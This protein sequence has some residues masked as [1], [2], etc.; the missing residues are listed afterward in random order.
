MAIKLDPSYS[1][2]KDGQL[3]LHEVSYVNCSDTDP[4]RMRGT[5]GRRLV[6]RESKTEKKEPR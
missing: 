2:D 6:V 3:T 1:V 4:Y 5:E